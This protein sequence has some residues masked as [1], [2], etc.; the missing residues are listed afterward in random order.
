[1]KTKLRSHYL[2]T[3]STLAQVVWQRWAWSVRERERIEAER[4]AAQT[5]S[6]T[7]Q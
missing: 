1:M 4:L 3:T 5:A 2:R 6:E 7:M